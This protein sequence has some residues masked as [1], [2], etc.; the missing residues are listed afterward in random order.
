V[1]LTVEWMRGGKGRE[2]E[3]KEAMKLKG[4]LGFLIGEE[5]KKE[6]HDD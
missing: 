4:E 2:K 1:R 3:G 6:T 5:L